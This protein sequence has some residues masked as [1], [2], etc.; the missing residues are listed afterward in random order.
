[1]IPYDAINFFKFLQNSSKTPDGEIE[2][3]QEHLIRKNPAL[4]TFVFGSDFPPFVSPLRSK[5][6]FS[7]MVSPLK[8]AH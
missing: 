5:N 3:R 1:M 8:T 4:Q 2:A 6:K 7:P